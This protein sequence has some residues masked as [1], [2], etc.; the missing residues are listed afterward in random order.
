MKIWNKISDLNKTCKLNS[1]EDVFEF[2]YANRILSCV[3]NTEFDLKD[4]MIMENL[5]D[6]HSVGCTKC[7][8]EYLELD[9]E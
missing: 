8:N 1:K 5:C 7:L 2:M 3:I 4:K 6:K 9:Y